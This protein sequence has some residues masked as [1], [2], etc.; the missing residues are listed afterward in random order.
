MDCLAEYGRTADLI[1][2]GR[3]KESWGPDT[4]LLEAALMGTGK[5]V[6]IAPAGQAATAL[7]GEV[8]IAWKDT[9]EAGDY[10]VRVIASRPGVHVP[11]ESA[12]IRW[13]K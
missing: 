1:V 7:N 13:Q 5:P 4:V 8:G 9:R 3:D 11:A 6:L 10:T 12:L 2:M